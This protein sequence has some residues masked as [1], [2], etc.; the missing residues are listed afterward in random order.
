M[1]KII[2]TALVIVGLTGLTTNIAIAANFAKIDKNG[3]VCRALTWNGWGSKFSTE[4]LD[5][6]AKL[7]YNS[8][9]GDGIS[10][11]FGAMV[12]SKH[13]SAPLS[14]SHCQNG[15]VTLNWNEPGFTGTVTGVIDIPNNMIANV[16]GTING[17]DVQGNLIFRGYE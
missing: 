10:G 6:D 7:Y 13:F 8:A 12:D 1:K 5:M 4:S 3:D 16:T 17:Q 2:S 9:S 11:G 14:D 15:V